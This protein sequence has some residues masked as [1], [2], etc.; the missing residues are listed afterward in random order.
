MERESKFYMPD[1]G[2]NLNNGPTH[3][4]NRILTLNRLRARRAYNKK[5]VNSHPNYPSLKQNYNASQKELQN[6]KNYWKS[7]TNENIANNNNVT[8][9]RAYRTRRRNLKTSPANAAPGAPMAL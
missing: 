7:T 1:I 6:I 2:N 8:L 3:I 5:F 9:W 4:G